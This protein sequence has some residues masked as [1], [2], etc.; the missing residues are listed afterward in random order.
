[1]SATAKRTLEALHADRNPESPWVF[2]YKPGRHA[3]QPV[4]DVK[5]RFHAALEATEIQDFTWHDL[6]PVPTPLQALQ[7]RYEAR[8]P[9]DVRAF[10]GAFTRALAT[11]LLR[12]GASI[13][14]I[15]DVLRHQHPQTTEIYAKV[16]LARLRLLAPPW[17]SGGGR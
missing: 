9:R 2:P 14:D 3:G 8:V 4:H 10:I 13:A 1:M 5:N 16:D 7:A 12:R 6:R 17:R 15:G 11:E